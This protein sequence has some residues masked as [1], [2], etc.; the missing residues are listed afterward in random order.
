MSLSIIHFEVSLYC[1]DKNQMQQIVKELTHEEIDFD[2]SVEKTNHDGRQDIYRIDIHDTP[3][4]N[5]LKTIAK[6]A[7]RNDCK[8]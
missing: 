4:A 6:I 1:R 7:K 5:N 2:F 8:I 3:W